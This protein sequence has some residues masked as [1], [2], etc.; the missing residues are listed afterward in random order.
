LGK[1]GTSAPYTDVRN[2]EVDSGKRLA[3]EMILFF[4]GDY[5]RSNRVCYESGGGKDDTMA[6][7]FDGNGEWRHSMRESGYDRIFG[8]RG[9]SISPVVAPDV[10][11][12]VMRSKHLSLSAVSASNRYR[13][14]M[15]AY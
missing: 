3:T 1:P 2:C 8:G 4:G 12:S 15:V 10:T 5:V 7:G 6:G 14:C 13:D 9:W 11:N